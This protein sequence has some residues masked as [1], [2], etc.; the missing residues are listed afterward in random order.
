MRCRI[1]NLIRFMGIAREHTLPNLA[2]WRSYGEDMKKVL[3]VGASGATGRLVVQQLLQRDTQV[4]AIVRNVNSLPEG[5]AA[6]PNLQILEA[7]IAEMTDAELKPHVK[8]CEAVISC[9]GHKLTLKGVF[10]QPRRLVAD[11]VETL[12]RV[13]ESLDEDRKIKIILMNTSG[14]TNH[15]IPEKPPF[16]Q[17][18]VISLVR[19]LVPPH[20][21]NE[22]AA[23]F[24]RLKVGQSHRCIEWVAVRPDGL[25]DEDCV[26]DYEICPSPVR[27]VIFDAGSTS[28][29][30]VADFMSHLAVDENLWNSWKGRMPVIYNRPLAG[31]A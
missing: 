10:G 5:M 22:Q 16:S 13:I 21:D 27:N 11:T 23:N 20:G 30:N 9:L 25:T 4:V 24:L 15:D 17:E 6:E 31:S 12:V 7:S 18:L 28:R 8:D 19:C 1:E 14:N 2:L 29:I 3:V 26:T